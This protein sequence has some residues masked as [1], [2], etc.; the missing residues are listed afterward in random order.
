MLFGLHREGYTLGAAPIA[1]NSPPPR[2]PALYI[3]RG[4]ARRSPLASR[5]GSLHDLPSGG[6]NARRLLV[7]ALA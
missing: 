4:T 7:L 3:R 1:D 5:A 6:R 2:P